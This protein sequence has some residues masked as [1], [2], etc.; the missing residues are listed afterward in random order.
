MSYQ[1]GLPPTPL[2]HP[3]DTE[4]LRRVLAKQFHVAA[5]YAYT[6][7]ST[8]FLRDGELG[9]SGLRLHP[10]GPSDG[11]QGLRLVDKQ[12]Q[13][14][15]APRRPRISRGSAMPFNVTRGWQTRVHRAKDRLLKAVGPHPLDLP[16]ANIIR[17]SSR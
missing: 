12:W 14:R 11:L 8:A 5:D 15:S 2:A 6:N 3:L 9:R 16:R 10:E 1:A 7:S 4:E 13:L 17:I